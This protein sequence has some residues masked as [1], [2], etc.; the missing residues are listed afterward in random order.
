MDTN[1]LMSTLSAAVVVIGGGAA[2]LRWLGKKIDKR[3]QE[4]ATTGEQT[5]AQVTPKTGQLTLGDIVEQSASDI[6]GIHARLDEQAKEARETREL[7]LDAR[8]LARSAH[9]RLDHHL[10]NDHGAQAPRAE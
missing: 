1:T 6:Q 4:V 2:G 8:T 7:A 5:A 3:I 9:D 10:I